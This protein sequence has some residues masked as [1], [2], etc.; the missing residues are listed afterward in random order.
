LKPTDKQAAYVQR[1]V[2]CLGTER[3][4]SYIKH[5]YS[6]VDMTNLEKDQAQKIITG[7]QTYLPRNHW[8]GNGMSMGW[9]QSQ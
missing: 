5:F 2:D 6:S 4:E 3:V 9:I 8:G 1:I 7:L